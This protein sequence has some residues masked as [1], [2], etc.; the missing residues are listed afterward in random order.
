MNKT[1]LF[2]LAALGLVIPATPL[3]AHHGT[4]GSYDQNKT[5]TVQGTVK[6][7]WWRNPHSAL[8]VDAKDES[9]KDVTYALEM[10][11]PQTLVKFGYTRTTF[12]PGDKVI[13]PMHPSFTN[14]VNG[15][16][17]SRNV[18]VNGTKLKDAGGPTGAPGGY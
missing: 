16:A 18:T 10:G 7:F 9:G 11:S 6:E 4:A 5:V 1:T 15:E 13:M 17:L 3:L 8:F 2:G 12:R 14:P